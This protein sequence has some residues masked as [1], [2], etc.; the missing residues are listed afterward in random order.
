[1]PPKYTDAENDVARDLALIRYIADFNA[2]DRPERFALLLA[3]QCDLQLRLTHQHH[4]SFEFVVNPVQPCD[5]DCYIVS[6]LSPYLYIHGSGFISNIEQ[7]PFSRRRG[8]RIDSAYSEALDPLFLT[9][10]DDEPAARRTFFRGRNMGTVH[11]QS[12]RIEAINSRFYGHW[13]LTLSGY[14]RFFD[15]EGRL[16]CDLS[17][18]PQTQKCLIVMDTRFPWIHDPHGVFMQAHFHS[19]RPCSIHIYVSGRRTLSFDTW[20]RTFPGTFSDGASIDSTL[21]DS[22]AALTL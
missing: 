18:E 15:K 22:F 3:I 7:N 21:T 9:G 17:Y 1:M 12:V 8:C 16:L 13:P 4:G 20:A 5:G 2:S 11:I 14:V 19:S 6:Y 10:H